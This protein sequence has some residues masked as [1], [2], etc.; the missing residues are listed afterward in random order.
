MKVLT[1]SVLLS[2]LA[3]SAS[4]VDIVC[5]PFPFGAPVVCPPGYWRCVK[6]PATTTQTPSPMR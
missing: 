5:G 2:I 6:A 1:V 4:P 3:V